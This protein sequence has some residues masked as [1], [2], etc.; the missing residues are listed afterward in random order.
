[1]E[2]SY[3]ARRPFG[4]VYVSLDG[5]SFPDDFDQRR[6][7]LRGCLNVRLVRG[8]ESILLGS[9]SLIEDQI[10][11]PREDATDEKVLLR[12]APSVSGGRSFRRLSLLTIG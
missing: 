6:I 12:R 2:T 9:F 7:G 8:L 5:S 3:T 1:M 10:Y 11:P 4:T